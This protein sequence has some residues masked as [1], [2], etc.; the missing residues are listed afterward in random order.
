MTI[1][2]IVRL[3]RHLCSAASRVHIRMI[4]TDPLVRTRPTVRISCTYTHTVHSF[5][6]ITF[7]LVRLSAKPGGRM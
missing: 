5:P 1:R 6:T 7:P 2:T 4:L 3:D